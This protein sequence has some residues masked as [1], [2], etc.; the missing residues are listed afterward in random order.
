MAKL[1][2]LNGR[3]RGLTL[4]LSEFAAGIQCDTL[5]SEILTL[6]KL[7]VL[8]TIGVA[9]AAVS[10][11]AP[12][13]L[14]EEFRMQGGAPKA[15]VIGHPDRLPALSAALVN[16]TIAHAIDYDDVNM[17]VPGHLSAVLVPA[18][19]AL[20]EERGIS[21]KELVAALVAGH[22]V[23]C[24]IGVAIAP[25][26][27]AAGFHATGTIGTLGAAT[28]CAR[29]IHA[30]VLTIANAIGIAATQ[31]AALKSMAGTMCKPLHAGKAAHDGLLAARLAERGFTSRPDSIE[32]DQGFALTHSANFNPDLAMTEPPAGFYL[33]RNLFKHHAAC[34]VAHAPMEAVRALRESRGVRPN[35]ID[36]LTIRVDRIGGSICSHPNPHTGLEAKFSLPM[37]AALA[38]TGRDTGDPSTYSDAIVSVPEL[39][40]IMGRVTV[41]LQEGWDLTVA[42]VDLRLADGT[43]VTQRWDS[44]IPPADVQSQ[45][46]QME[47]KF[48]NLTTPAIGKD[49]AQRLLH[50]VSRLEEL[51]DI[52]TLAHLWR[53]LL[54]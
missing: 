14:L 23:C 46:K 10:E 49:R 22:E 15:G 37:A 36:A 4:A 47:A 52:G 39:R 54:R 16:G 45:K 25:G 7:C 29:L 30:D 41:D 42:E 1:E 5:P 21:G 44:G 51:T 31:T 28:A 20:A 32:C 53:P 27:Y 12:I 2:S 17:A 33:T 8:D 35:E 19:L 38:L 6:A 26:H 34:M 40:S 43:M 50:D 18:L 11:P 13:M 48:L 3:G 9:L 24:R